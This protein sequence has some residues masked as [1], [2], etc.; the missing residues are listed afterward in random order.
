MSNAESPLGRVEVLGEEQGQFMNGHL[1]VSESVEL[2][3]SKSAGFGGTL[4]T[5]KASAQG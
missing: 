1:Q 4:A 3:G 2:I 5:A